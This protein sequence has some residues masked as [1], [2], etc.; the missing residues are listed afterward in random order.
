M[1]HAQL[2][3]YIMRSTIIGGVCG[4]IHGYNVEQKLIVQHTITGMIM[5]PW[6]PIAVPLWVWKYPGPCTCS[7]SSPP[8][9]VIS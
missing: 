6:I 7:A 9:K 2:L 8:S 4:A 5:G 3:N 1:P